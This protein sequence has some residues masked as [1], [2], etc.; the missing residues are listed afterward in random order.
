MPELNIYVYPQHKAGA[1]DAE[2]ASKGITA[3][4]DLPR[5]LERG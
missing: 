4:Q 3:A 1:N 5:L 2:E